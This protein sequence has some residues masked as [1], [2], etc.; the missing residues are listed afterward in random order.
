MTHA[1]R[2]AIALAAMAAIPLSGGNAVVSGPNA[3]GERQ[4]PTPEIGDGETATLLPDGTWL[5]IGGRQGD[6]TASDAVRLW[7]PAAGRATVL[8]STLGRARAHHSAT[9]LPD[10][11]V[12]ILGG[13]DTRGRLERVVEIFDPA[14]N[15]FDIVEATIGAR[16]SHSATLLTDGRVL[17]AGGVDEHGRPRSDA[18]LWNPSSGEVLQPIYMATA[19]RGH[20]ATLQEDGSVSIE[21]GGPGDP[22]REREAFYPENEAFV[23]GPPDAGTIDDVRFGGSLPVD[24]ATGVSVDTFV[25]LRFSAPLR[26]RS[27]H[28]ATVSLSGP[29]GVV[30]AAVVPA[31]QGRLVFVKPRAPLTALTSY[32]VSVTGVRADD[33]SAE[34][35][36]LVSITFT[37]ERSVDSPAR[38][39][40][41]EEWTP[42]AGSIGRGWRANRPP[43]P[44]QSLPPLQAPPG[45]TALAGQA[46][47][48]NGTPLANVTLEIEGH[49]ARSDKTGRFLVTLS[50]AQRGRRELVIDGTTANSQGRTY[51][52]F[53]FGLVIGAGRTNVLPFTIWM[54]RLDT[55]HA[56]TIP[57]PTTSATV[58]TTPRIPGLELH[59]APNTVIRDRAGRVVRRLSITPIPVDRPPFPLPRDTEVPIYFTIQPGGAYVHVYGQPGVKGAR[60]IYPNYTAQKP[61]ETMDFWRYDPEDRGWDVYGQGAVSR[62]GRQ[63]VPNPGVSIY[64]FTG[65]MISTAFSP[66]SWWPSFAGLFGGDPVDLATGLF[67]YEK[68]DLFLPDVMPLA[69][70]RTYRPSDA[71]SRSFGRG[72]RHLYDV[73]LWRPNVSSYEDVALIL[74]DGKRIEYVCLNPEEPLIGDLRFEHTATPTAFYQSTFQWIGFGWALA[75]RD[76]TVYEFGDNAPLQSIRDRF[77][78]VT[79][80]VRTNGQHGNIVKIISPHNRW[81]AFTYDGS[82]R[83][84]QAKDNLGRTVGYEY[85]GSGRLWKVTDAAGGVTEYTYDTSHQ[86]LTIEDPRG[87]TYL[88]NVYDANGRVEEQT[89]A[90]TGVY[91]FDYTLDGSGQVTQTDLTDPEGRVQRAAFNADGFPLTVTEAYGTGLARTTTYTYQSGSNLLTHVVDALSRETEYTYDAF[92]NVTSVVELAGTADEITTTYTYEPAYNQVATVTDPLNHTTSFAYDSLGR[93]TAVTDALSHQT[94]FTY[95]GAGQPLTVTDALSKTTTFG[96]ALGNL[97]SITSPLGHVESRFVDGGGRLVQVTDARGL[98]TRFDYNAF[99]QV[100][101]ILDPLNGETS[102]TYDGNG[103]L[104][105]LTD[106]R[107]KTTTWTYDGMDRVETR[108]DPLS[109]DES[110]AYDLLGNLTSW[111]DRKGQVTAYQ[112]DGLNRQTFVGFGTTGAPPTYA[113]TITTTFDAGD[114]PT[115]IVDSVAGTIERT[116]DLLDRLTEEITP[117]GTL[118]YTYDD[119]SRRASMTVAGQ[120]AISYTLDDADRLTGVTRGTAAVSLAYDNADRRTSLTLPNGIVV[121]YAYDDD[122][123]LTGLTYTQGM[124]TLGTL[125]YEYDANGQRTSVDGTY[126]RTNLPAALTSATYDD[127]NQIATFGGVSFTYDANGN[128]TNDGSRT[129]TWDARNQL[130]SLTGPVNGSFAYDGVGRRRSKTIGG[131][132]TQFLYDGLN[133]VQ[134]LSGG[135]PTAN[136]LT[137]LGIDEYFTRTDGAGVREF[138]TDALGSTVALADASGTVQT[139]YS[140]EP[141]G[142]TTIT[143]ASTTSAYGFTGRE[144]DGTGLYH[145]RARYHHPTA[146]RFVS[147]DPLGFADGP[148]LALYVANR[149]PNFVDPLGLDIKL[150]KDPGG[151][152]PEWK[153]DPSHQDPHGTRY[154]DPSGRP[155]D[156]HPGREGEKGWKGKDHWHDPNNH[157]RKHLPPG[158]SVPD[159][160]PLPKQPPPPRPPVPP[161]LPRLP[162]PLPLIVNPCILDPSFFACNPLPGRKPI[163]G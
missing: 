129:Y 25:A 104:L 43:S 36:P 12:L 151:L 116:Y 53:E 154:R 47:R 87:I 29:E 72:S 24:G 66:P 17:V 41:D 58:V 77:G 100:T 62:D 156:W 142:A 127:A 2:I 111:T 56:V 97:V 99:S 55:A 75:L 134:E 155:L 11:K 14:S 148:H 1:L 69:L 22:E 70:T 132:T 137:G 71:T 86:M 126:A 162:F 48:L 93:V 157:G 79:R 152:G 45:V 161:W 67:V 130:A 57:S 109:R 139:E 39:A 42:D 121:E 16:A 85:D 98:S 34:P 101:K 140:Y 33:P 114:R 125:T 159:P 138:L 120:T 18:A 88:T 64:E 38:P 30:D 59:L 6:G 10:G 113:S 21:G 117:E 145:Y 37:T 105:T 136:L 118:T 13:L 123:R 128:L 102:F 8:R 32:T 51:G 76:G 96:Y 5:L 44:W 133:P 31:E 82:D 50:E 135:T 65:A 54:P 106:A 74:P 26:V 90:D 131:T 35:A 81:I 94:T 147:E 95:N 83:I 112:Y 158:S 144:N 9:L 89:L 143:G 15:R 3:V 49:K 124:S 28:D 84:T 146:Q 23:V 107:S 52:V 108:T 141:F 40:D 122:S 150:P 4:Q 115:E 92:G 61:G 27:L 20:R 60:L 63:V 68:T 163:D 78:N 73:H 153:P 149:S 103:N 119:A 7:D 80:L 110:F 160:A 19:R 91:A 46:L